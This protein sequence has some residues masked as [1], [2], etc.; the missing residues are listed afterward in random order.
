M[1]GAQVDRV[2]AP[3]VSLAR[4][5]ICLWPGLPQLW[6]VGAWSGLALA[7][8]FGCLLNLLLVTSFVWTGLVEP[9]LRVAAWT[10][11]SVLW[12][13]SG[14][15]SWRWCRQQAA[16]QRSSPEDLFPQALNEYLKGNWFEA[17]AMCNQ[18]VASDARDIEAHLLLAAIGRHTGRWDEARRRLEELR[19]LEGSAKWDF[20]MARELERLSPARA[21]TEAVT[22]GIEEVH[23]RA[24]P[25]M[26]GAA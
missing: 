21:G 2:L 1:S 16:G 18:L 4:P 12:A 8:G 19:R 13:A 23:H 25:E 7:A 3:R 17:E 9:A 14:L 11:V 20:E 10:A 22:D 6:I 26:L 24:A 15:A 5:F